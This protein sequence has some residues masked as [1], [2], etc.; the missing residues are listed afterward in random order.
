METGIAVKR[1][2][3]SERERRA[4]SARNRGRIKS[5]PPTARFHQPVPHVMGRLANHERVRFHEFRFPSVE[6]GFG[7]L[8]FELCPARRADSWSFCSKILLGGSSVR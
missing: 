8:A 4:S 7:R 3:D 2:R 5:Q 1:P 6:L